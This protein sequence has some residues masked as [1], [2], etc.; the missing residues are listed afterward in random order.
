MR[1]SMVIKEA[2]A[3]YT[4]DVKEEFMFA[5][6]C[7]G[8]GEWSQAFDVVRANSGLFLGVVLPVALFL[9]APALVT[10][11]LSVGGRVAFQILFV[12][13]RLPEAAEWLWRRAVAVATERVRRRAARRGQ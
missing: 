7:L 9:R 11:A 6:E 2:L 3:S 10:L 4:E 8:R 12:T 1:D 13:G 5:L